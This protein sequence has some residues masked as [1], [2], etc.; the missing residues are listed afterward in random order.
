M[1]DPGCRQRVALWECSE[2]AL[3][4]PTPAIP[5]SDGVHQP[6]PAA[7]SSAALAI[8]PA[9]SPATSEIKPRRYSRSID[10]LRS[11]TSAM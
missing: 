4:E 11:R 3:G 2:P 9:T 8:E 7:R 6:L 1:D 10:P 5:G